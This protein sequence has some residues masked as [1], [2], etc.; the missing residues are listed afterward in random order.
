MN[1]VVGAISLKFANLIYS[2]Y[3]RSKGIV[4]DELVVETTFA[5]RRYQKFY[6]SILV[7][8]PR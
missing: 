6:G 7:A 8:F 2:S 5:V 4:L 3:V 1:N